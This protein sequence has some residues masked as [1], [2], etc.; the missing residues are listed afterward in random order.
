MGSK[1]PIEWLEG[2]ATW[3]FL[4]G[5]T[6]VS[7][8]C[9][10]CYAERVVPRLTGHIP[11]G[12]SYQGK[13]NVVV[14]EDKLQ[15]PRQWT[16]GR[17]VFVNSLSDTFH[18]AVPDRVRDAAWETMAASP[19]HTF[20]VLTKRPMHAR[21]YLTRRGAPLPNVW[22]GVSAEDQP[23]L[24]QRT[25]HLRGIPAAK[26]FVSLEPM[27]AAVKP[28]RYL[29]GIDW[30]I[31]GGESGRLARTCKEQW[32]RDVVRDCLKAGVPVYVKQLGTQWANGVKELGPCKIGGKGQDI[33]LWPKD[34]QVREVPR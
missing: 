10:W 22:V 19:Q 11:E 33:A 32:V 7:D 26:R 17:K 9:R 25:E 13:G 34:L 29:E 5:C 23:T 12:A 16:R 28:G 20:L 2:G 21:E 8:G 27:V 24:I 31:V 6:K 15:I 14:C 1:S 4:Y 18:P 30:L 3:N